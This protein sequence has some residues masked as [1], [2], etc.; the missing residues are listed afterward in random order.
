MKDCVLTMNHALQFASH[1]PVMKTIRLILLSCVAKL[2]PAFRQVALSVSLCSALC[3]PWAIHAGPSKP[4]IVFIFV[5]NLGSGVP[6]C[7]GSKVH[8]TPNIDRMAAEGTRFTSF[9]VASGVCT[10]GR[11][12]AM[13]A[14]YPPLPKGD[15]PC[16]SIRSENLR[17]GVEDASLLGMVER[18]RDDPKRGVEARTLLKQ[19][20]DLVPD[21][22]HYNFQ[23]NA[24]HLLRNALGGFIERSQHE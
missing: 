21:Q 18:F 16:P 8:R 2:R 11:A 23:S 1:Q 7:Y 15:P 20:A 14:C 6:G 4:N 3:V 5:D 19:A 17:D 9:Y 22:R 12:A 13:T 10:P 24:Y